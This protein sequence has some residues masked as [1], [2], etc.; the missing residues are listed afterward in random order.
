MTTTRTPSTSPARTSKRSI[1]LAA[2]T[3]AAVVSLANLAVASISLA[4]GTPSVL[5][6]TP[7]PYISFSVVAGVVGAIGW[8]LIRDRA[9]SPQRLL[10][11][12]AIV[13]LVASLLPL[14]ALGA[15][16][17]PELGWAPVVTLG[18]MHVVSVGVAVAT[19]AVLLPVSRGAVEATPSQRHP[20]G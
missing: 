8:A 2:L 12:L 5:Q 19:L 3:T 11:I 13:T 4:L 1:A 14:V 6:L 7:G 16:V 9:G 15:S 18:L 17:V 10:G 20:V